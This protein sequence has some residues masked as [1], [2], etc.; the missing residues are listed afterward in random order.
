MAR[1][2]EA[3]RINLGLWDEMAPV[4]GRSYDTSAGHHLDPVQVS[5]L[6][7]LRGKKV[8]HLQCHIGTDTLALARLGGDVT[9]VDFSRES[10]K[11]ARELANKAGLSVR[12]IETPLFDLQG[13]LTETFDLVYTSIGVLCWLSDLDLWAGVVTGCLKPGGVF[14]IME[15][16]PF[17]N[18]FDDEAEGLEIRH[19]YFT[20]GRP[21]DWPGNFSDYS[22]GAY[23]V[24]S[25][26]RE[27]TWTMGDIHNS[28]TKAGLR[29]EF[30]HE[31]DFLHWKALPCMEAG[32]DRFWRLPEPF[33]RIP[34]LFSLKAV[35][36]VEA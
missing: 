15:S 36:P 24:K 8:L 19:P 9:G 6:G 25:P 18:V 28:L 29:I 35:K 7:D 26:S 17:L 12:F 31:Y 16:H 33:N 14:Y 22:D 3:E 11:V 13:V 27:F 10:L 4:H 21:A 2:L 1:D 32:E 5:E 34:L 23:I 30:I 20:G